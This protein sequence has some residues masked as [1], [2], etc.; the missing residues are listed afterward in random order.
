MDGFDDT[1]VRANKQYNCI[2]Y[3]DFKKS[4]VKSNPFDVSVTSLTMYESYSLQR[5]VALARLRRLITD[6]KIKSAFI[7]I[8]HCRVLS[9]CSLGSVR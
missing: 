5:G 3:S 1:T 4:R 9:R 7:S 6:L 8:H 2:Q